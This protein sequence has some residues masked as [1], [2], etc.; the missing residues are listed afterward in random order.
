[1]PGPAPRRN[2]RSARAARSA[3]AVLLIHASNVFFAFSSYFVKLASKAV[4]GW[5]SSLARFVVGGAIG[6]ITL[7]AIRK[8]FKVNRFG[9]WAGRG[10]FGAV[11]MVLYYFSISLGSAGRATL[12]NA[13]YPVFVAII[14]ILF[15]KKRPR[16]GILA[17]IAVST[18]GAFLV[19][20][21]GAKITPLG[22]GLGLLSGIVAGLS[23]HFN[24]KAS[25]T[26]DS[27]VIYLG[28]CLVGV[29]CCGFSAPRAIGLKPLIG[30][31]LLMVGAT[32]YYGQVAITS[33]LRELGA[34]EGSLISY[35]K[36][37]IAI[38]I[39]WAFL[40]ERISLRFLAGTALILGGLFLD[41][42][43]GKR[44]RRG[45]GALTPSPP[46]E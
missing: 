25:E 41:R 33:G 21:D 20:W 1:M 9:V 43:S 2:A 42:G 27:I 17:G 26:E 40:G 45:S 10:L 4:D 19:L 31:A 7:A 23:L 44:L 14:E 46:P 35:L 24:K 36:V 3:K 28:V 11:S 34:T 8:P 39:S 30:L 18:V 15:L 12:L 13:T 16:A 32:A 6:L 37:P 5:F 38:L 29:L 22:D